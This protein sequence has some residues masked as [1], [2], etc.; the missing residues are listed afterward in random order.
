M[1]SMLRQFLTA[2]FALTLACGGDDDQSS[3]GDGDGDGSDPENYFRATFVLVDGGTVE[4]DVRSKVDY[5]Q[6]FG[7]CEGIN[8]AGY[9]A[10][11]AWDLDDPPEPAVYDLEQTGLS[12]T[13]IVQWPHAEGFRGTTAGVGTLE[14]TEV[15]VAPGDVV[16][17]TFDEIDMEPEAGDPLDRVQAIELGEFRC[18]LP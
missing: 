9:G 4:V 7:L 17:G 16:A 2:V 6:N 12:P 11:T 13:L 3:G 8:G 1:A 18:V 14:L 5:T 10:G 15:G